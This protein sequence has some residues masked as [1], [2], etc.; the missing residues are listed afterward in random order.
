MVANRLEA[1]V[2]LQ[3]WFLGESSL[4]LLMP[5]DR[6]L[7]KIFQASPLHYQEFGGQTLPLIILTDICTNIRCKT[8]LNRFADLNEGV[9]REELGIR[10]HPQLRADG[11]VQTKHA[12]ITQ[13][14]KSELFV[15]TTVTVYYAAHVSEL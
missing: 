13:F 7:N 14:N 3:G 9:E 1:A 11:E 8:G 10:A 4:L 6:V 2:V 12:W 5:V 15:H